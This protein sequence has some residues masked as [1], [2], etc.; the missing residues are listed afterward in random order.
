MF[1]L[2]KALAITPAVV[3]STAGTWMVG[4]LLP[5]GAGAALFYGGLACAIT[6][7]LGRG[8]DLAI[9]V[10]FRGRR[11]TKTEA[12]A[13][14][15]AI[16]L[17]CQVGLGPPTVRIW[18]QGSDRRVVAGGAGRRSVVV[19]VALV[20]AVQDGH[21]P[22]DQA[23]A[24]MARAAG[25]VRAGLVRSDLLISFWTLPWQ[26][27]SA[28]VGAITKMFGQLPGTRALWQLRFVVG[29]ITVGQTTTEGHWPLAVL[30]AA[31]TGL[32]YT[33]PRWE[34]AWDKQLLRA[35]DHQ[36]QEHGLAAPLARFLRRCPRN[37]QTRERIHLLEGGPP[38]PALR[39]VRTQP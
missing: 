1:V 29:V 27:L 28:L 33:I 3:V 35:G 21:L 38:R 31:I 13:L 14:A 18:V 36:A 17:L 5:A 15:P 12:A 6:L 4:S 7:A 10:L 34:Q 30:V 25:L 16:T 37:T 20:T 39:L 11:L 2:P 24:L 22:Q 9:R 8:E 23:A 19:S 26:I 32:S